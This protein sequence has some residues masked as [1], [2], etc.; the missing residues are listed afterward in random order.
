MNCPGASRTRNRVADLALV[1][2]HPLMTAR[3]VKDNHGTPLARGRNAVTHDHYPPA[4]SATSNQKQS[5]IP[6]KLP[7]VHMPT[8]R[9][10]QTSLLPFPPHFVPSCLRG[11][12]LRR[13]V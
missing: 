10:A 1:N 12:I 6:C 13:P 2:L 3:T 8:R 9:Y 5:T 7:F 11:S 4:K